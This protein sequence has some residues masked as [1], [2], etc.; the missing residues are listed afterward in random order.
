M[1]EKE[2]LEQEIDNTLTNEGEE[3]GEPTTEP[4]IEPTTEPTTQS[5]EPETEPQETETLYKESEI[6]EKFDNIGS[7]E[8]LITLA[9]EGLEHR[10]LVIESALESGVHSMGNAFNKEVFTKTFAN[11]ST[12]DIE[13][14]KKTWEEQANAQFVKD[15]VSQQDFSNENSEEIRRVDMKQFKTSNY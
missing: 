6:L 15:K 1:A 10:N 4:L 3:E 14:M 8:E 13:Q 2:E 7:L 9:K 12:K 11:M 5:N